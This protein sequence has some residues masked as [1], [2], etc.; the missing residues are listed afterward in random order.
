LRVQVHCGGGKVKARMKR[1]DGSGA[2]MALLL[3]ED[4]LAAGAVTLKPLRTD[5]AQ[6]TLT[7]AALIDQL[8]GPYG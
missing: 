7:R 2:D 3:G 1:A 8:R 4:E 5:G 6:Q